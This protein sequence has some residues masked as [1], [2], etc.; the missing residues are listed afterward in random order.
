MAGRANCVALKSVSERGKARN[1]S[2]KETLRALI[3]PMKA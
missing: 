1:G 2:T 3:G